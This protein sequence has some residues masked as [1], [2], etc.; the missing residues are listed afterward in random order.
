MREPF[1][2][3]KLQAN[4]ARSSLAKLPTGGT[5]AL[6]HPLMVRQNLVAFFYDGF[7]S[8]ASENIVIT[9]LVVYLLSLGATQAQIGLMS[10]L[11]S[12]TAALVLIPG[13]ILVERIGHRKDITVWGGGVAARLMILA[14]ALLPFLLHGPVLIT[15]AIAASITRDMLNNL[16]YPAWMSLTGEIVPIEGRGRYFSSRNIAMAAVGIL[17]TFVAGLILTR[18]AQPIGYQGAM[19][20]AF[21]IGLF[22][23]YA[24]WRIQDPNPAAVRPNQGLLDDPSSRIV[25][26]SRAQVLSSL[27]NELR[28]QPAFLVLLGTTF[29]WNVSLNIAGPF[30]NVYMVKNLHATAD[31]IGLTSIASTLSTMLL[32]RKFGELNDR[33]G[34]RKLQL[35]SGLLIPIVPVLWVFVQQP[36]HIIPLN[37]LSGALWGAFS[38]ANFNYL[39]SLMPTAQRARY[40]ALF[41]ITVT[42]ALAI[43][44]AIGS[45]V[46]THVGFFA[47]FLI[48]GAGRLF[49]ASLFARFSPAETIEPTTSPG[50]ATG[51]E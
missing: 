18:V 13:A 22:S 3:I 19:L 7:F 38:L 49:S 32:Q 39:L 36:W 4:L 41:Q 12:L 34:A 25:P 51:V 5:W 2:R 30:F 35:V 9:Y 23:T 45:V 11:S 31:M 26:R 14:L 27:V 16:T 42:L 6:R 43:G 47:V 37:I 50:S 48:S 28:D 29:L 40:S 21:A 24:F 33:W 1:T 10:S 46:V 44:A 20:V 15:F 17:V 8:S